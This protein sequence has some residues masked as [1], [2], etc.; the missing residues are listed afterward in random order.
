[1]NPAD[2]LLIV[3][4][5]AL[6]LYGILGGADFGAGVWELFSISRRTEKQRQHIYKAIG[7]V[8]EANHVWLIFIIVI[9][10]NG[11]PIAFSALSRAL[12]LPLLIAL[13]G[14]VFRGASYVFAYYGRGSAGIQSLW[15]MMF[16]IAS[17]LTPLFLGF[18]A[19]S[20]AAGNLSISE[21]GEFDGSFLSGWI[22]P[23]SIFTGVY[24]VAMCSYLTAVFLT[25]E[26][27]QTDEF[28]LAAIWKRRSLT[29]GLLMGVLSIIGLVF[30]AI[31]APDLQAGFIRRGW[32]LVVISILCGTSSLILLTK[33]RYSLAV[34]ASS[35]AAAA[36]IAGWG[37]SQY[38][39]IVPPNLRADVAQAPDN[40]LWVMVGVIAVGSIL[41]LPAL[42]YLFVLFKHQSNLKSIRNQQ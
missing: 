19:G 22:S 1:M 14:I 37:V 9:L 3:L 28:D 15:E 35:G 32:P 18:C 2:L 34:V 26:A 10:M 31:D 41:M 4:L 36:V 5:M 13:T 21:T 23:L 25:R 6:I 17:T 24:T 16:A 42:G 33:Q 12:W 40:I 29:V 7:P 27:H 39:V 30:V 8:W 20:I 11:F 38:P